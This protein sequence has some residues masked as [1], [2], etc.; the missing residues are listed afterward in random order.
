MIK[1]LWF[2]GFFFI[3]CSLV[4]HCWATRDNHEKLQSQH[5]LFKHGKRRPNAVSF[6]SIRRPWYH[7]WSDSS[8]SIYGTTSLIPFPEKG[9]CMLTVMVSRLIGGSIEEGFVKSRWWM[10]STSSVLISEN[11]QTTYVTITYVLTNN[12]KEIATSAKYYMHEVFWTFKTYWIVSSFFKVLFF[13]CIGHSEYSWFYT[14]WSFLLFLLQ[15]TSCTRRAVFHVCKNWLLK[16]LNFTVK[17]VRYT[18]FTLLKFSKR[19]GW[20]RGQV[21]QLFILWQRPYSELWII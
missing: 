3:D 13:E 10:T 7:T 4:V 9:S 15:S 6:V 21:K 19:P 16:A 2:S 18:L 11:Y 1:Y 5:L 17:N 12:L 8:Y 14:V 20:S